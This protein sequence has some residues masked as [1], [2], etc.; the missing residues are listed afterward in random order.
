[1]FTLRNAYI[2]NANPVLGM[3]TPVSLAQANL[4]MRIVRNLLHYGYITVQCAQ[5]TVAK[6]V[7][8]RQL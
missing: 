5:P 1:M 3:A 8:K 7:Y 4:P 6:A 2:T